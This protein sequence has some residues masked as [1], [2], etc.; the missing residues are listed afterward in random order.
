MQL[1]YASFRCRFSV[2]VVV[3]KDDG[4]QCD[5]GGHQACL[6]SQ[7][8]VAAKSWGSGGGGGYSSY[9]LRVL[10]AGECEVMATSESLFV[11]VAQFGR[12][13]P[14]DGSK[15]RIDNALYLRPVSLV[16]IPYSLALVMTLAPRAETPPSG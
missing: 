2:D 15:S 9:S 8:P 14:N 13:P 5:L 3:L 1:I 10:I 7:S 11:V 6:A 16:S 12:D 4:L